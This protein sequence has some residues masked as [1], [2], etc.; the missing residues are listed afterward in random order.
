MIKGIMLYPEECLMGNLVTH[1]EESIILGGFFFLNYS[2]KNNTLTQDY[3]TF[4]I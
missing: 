4:Y 2:L 1:C 3:L